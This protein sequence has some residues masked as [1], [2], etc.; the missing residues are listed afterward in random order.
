MILGRLYRIIAFNIKKKIVFIK[1]R[2]KN[3]HNQTFYN[4]NSDVD[5]DISKILVGNY[6]YGQITIHDGARKN[7]QLKIGSYC[8]IAPG[9][10]FILSNEHRLDTITTFPLKYMKLKLGPEALGKGD[11]VLEDDVWIGLNAIICSGVRIGRGAVIAAGAIVTKNVEPY[12]IMGGNPAKLI[13]YRFDSELRKRLN[14]INLEEL[15]N[16]SDI[17]NIELFYE[18]LTL[19]KLENL[20]REQEKN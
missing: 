3:R 11:I 8:S 18:K 19:E 12:A 14:E 4:A 16:N 7:Y 1:Y 15:L 6:S 9:V 5:F 13:R 10:Q 17:N 2:L 20:I